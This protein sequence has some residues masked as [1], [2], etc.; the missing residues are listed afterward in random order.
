MRKPENFDILK[1]SGIVLA[2]GKSLRFGKDKSQV[3]IGKRSLLE[4]VVACVS[5]ICTDVLIIAGEQDIPQ[6]AG[7][8]RLK[9]V[10]DVYPGKGPLGGIY[11]GLKASPTHINLVV[12]GDMPFLNRELLS[13]M[14]SSADSFDVVI[15]RLGEFIEPLHA[16]YTKSCLSPI[17]RM[18]DKGELRVRQLLPTFRVKYID[19]KEIDK[20]DPHHLSFF[21]INTKTDLVK[22]QEIAQGGPSDKC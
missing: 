16:V 9:V 12:A 20:F 22:A 4:Q 1:A 15:P 10:T 11:T 6:I 2:G 3:K 21:N 7:Y 18:L 13:Y 19:S 5:S 17:E 14:L 8:P